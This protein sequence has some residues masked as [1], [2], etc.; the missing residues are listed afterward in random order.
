[1]FFSQKKRIL[2]RTY[3]K[4]RRDVQDPR[5]IL[6]I[7]AIQSALQMQQF[8]L[9]RL[10]STQGLCMFSQ[11]REGHMKQSHTLVLFLPGSELE[12]ASSDR[13]ASLFLDPLLLPLLWA[14]QIETG[15]APWT[16]AP[17]ELAPLLLSPS[18]QPV[19]RQG[20]GMCDAPGAAAAQHTPLSNGRTRVH[21]PSDCKVL[22]FV[23]SVVREAARS[24]DG[25]R[26]TGH[27][28]HHVASFKRARDRQS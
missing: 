19:P 10:V 6:N 22:T 24:C 12:E 4:Y 14:L 28:P 18:P 11:S 3:H 7:V 16:A 17:Q 21:T 2:L 20:L 25:W 13:S 23:D 8:V 5:R 15:P 9:V 26:Y 1:M 27:P